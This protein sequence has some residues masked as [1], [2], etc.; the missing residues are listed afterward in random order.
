M[1]DL[2]AF[3]AAIAS[4]A[5]RIVDLT[6]TLTPDFPV[7]VLPPEFT[8]ASPVRIEQLSRYDANGPGWYWNTITLGEHTGT[9]FDAPIHWYTGKDLANN[10]VDTLP[11]QTLIAPACVIDCS[12]EAAADADFLLTVPAVEAWEARHGRIP[13]RSWVLLRTDWSKRPP[14]AYANLRDDGAHTPGPDVAVMK[15]LVA[16]RG[17]LGFGTETIG[18]D[19][20]QAHHFDPPLPAH[21][22]LHGA[23]RYGLQCLCNLD[24]L[25]ETGAVIVAAPLKILNGSGSPLRVLALVA[26]GSGPGG[27]AR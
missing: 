26:S 5:V 21:H 25:P 17:I 23:G 16:E 24:Q 3:A 13:A 22:F 8:Q 12:A 9:H 11:V 18:T 4:G 27:Q 1:Y 15:W 2:L 10:A 20:G 14:R 19:A 7:I 6:F